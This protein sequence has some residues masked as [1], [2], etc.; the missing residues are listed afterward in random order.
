MNQYTHAWLAFRAVQRLDEVEHSRTN[1]AHARSLVSWFHGHRDDVIQ[2]AWYPD[3]V[4]HDNGT[5]HILKITPAEVGTNRFKKI[6]TTYLSWRLVK[7]SRLRKTSFVVDDKTNLPDR[8]EAIVHAVVDHLK[9]Q[10]W[11]EKGSPVS[12][13]DNQVA[14]LLFMLSHYIADAHMPFH[15]DSR[16]FSEGSKVHKDVEGAWEKEIE[17][18]F[19]I[20]TELERFVLENDYPRRTDA[21]GW[22]GSII[23]RVEE[24]LAGRDFSVTFGTGNNNVWDFMSAVCQH[25]YLLSYRFIPISHDH[26][27]VTDANW[28]SIGEIDFAD[29]STAALAD[30]VDSIARVWLRTWRRYRRW[31]D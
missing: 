3:E 30:A 14:Q 20:D 28:R 15:C 17:T 16:R 21:A 1:E 13:T 25:S 2:G 23:E 6:P 4:I 7:D 24:E 8:C 5:S 29:F 18:F 11:E 27:T 22:E 26:T 19:G 10:E 12:P 31:L 9:M